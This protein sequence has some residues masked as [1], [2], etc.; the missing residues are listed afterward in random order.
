MRLVYELLLLKQGLDYEILLSFSNGSLYYLSLF[1]HLATYHQPGSTIE[2]F[3]GKEI[4]DKVGHLRLSAKVWREA[5]AGRDENKMD[6]CS[7]A[8]ESMPPP[9]HYP[10]MN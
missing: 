9:N 4:F 10:M 1:M 8:F 6:E 3:A 7:T 2:H 5:G